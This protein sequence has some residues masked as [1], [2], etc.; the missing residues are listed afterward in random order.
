LDILEALT[1]A[2]FGA[3][4]FRGT[5]QGT[6]CAV[7]IVPFLSYLGTTEETKIWSSYM[8]GKSTQVYPDFTTSAS[9]YKQAALNASTFQAKNRNNSG[10]FSGA[11]FTWS[12]SCVL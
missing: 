10:V 5:M 7:I 1:I 12:G 4:Y 6:V 11:V 3:F 2:T 8:L 9:T